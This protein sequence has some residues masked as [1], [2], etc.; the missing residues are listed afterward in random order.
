MTESELQ[1]LIMIEAS[2]QGHRLFR[3][4]V[5]RALLIE[6]R[7][8]AS[9]ESIIQACIALAERYGGT[10]Y[11][12]TYGLCVGSSDLIGW[13]PSGQFEAVETKSEYGRLTPEQRN[14][15]AQVART[16]GIGLVARSVEEFLEKINGR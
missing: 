10:G 14:F 6:H 15:I 3:N 9:K 11:R 16:G 8:R 2:K 13:S 7:D 4:N 1:R 5:G 12:I